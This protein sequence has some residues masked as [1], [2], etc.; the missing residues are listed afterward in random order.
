MNLEHIVDTFEHEIYRKLIYKVT[1]VTSHDDLIEDT[2]L[3][4]KMTYR[5]LLNIPGLGLRRHLNETLHK[6]KD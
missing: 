4:E 5:P 2:H 6:I 3:I 1:D